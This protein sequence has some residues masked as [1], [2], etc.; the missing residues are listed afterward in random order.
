MHHERARSFSRATGERTISDNDPQQGSL[1][2][3]LRALR[4]RKWI[5]L[6]AAVLVP[7][8]AVA[9]S[10]RQEARYRASADV[11]INSQSAVQDIAGLV[12]TQ[13]PQRFLDTQAALA[14]EPLVARKVVAAV[15]GLTADQFLRNSSVGEKQNANLLVFSVTDHRPALAARLA[16][17]YAK[18][19]V[20]FERK[21]DSG[22][23][24]AALKNVRI[25]IA[26]LSERQS[27]LFASLTDKE[28]Q[29]LTALTL[30]TSRASVVR[31]PDG[32]VKTQPK[33]V[34][35]GIPRPASRPVRR[36]FVGAAS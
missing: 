17:E 3:W 12:T 26:G 8:V 11:L 7:A 24:Q 22:A 19:Y 10:L 9:Y 15:R 16:A 23:L 32:A 20:A 34:R 31:I 6:L 33:P 36:P 1:Q 14:R 13:D 2:H 25:R 21:L 28:Q 35:N 4:R 27:A 18:Q 29:L 5:V 30:Q